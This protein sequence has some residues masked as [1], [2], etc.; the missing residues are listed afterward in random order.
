MINTRAWKTFVFEGEQSK[1]TEWSF[2]FYSGMRSSSVRSVEKLLS[3]ER[4]DYDDMA[5]MGDPFVDKLTAELLDI[6]IQ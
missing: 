5:D 4:S 1:W 6:L 3:A 2:Q